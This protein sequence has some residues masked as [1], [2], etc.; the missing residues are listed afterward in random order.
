MLNELHKGMPAR[1]V[2]EEDYAT[3]CRT[4]LPQYKY[5]AKILYEM[6]PGIDPMLQHNQLVRLMVGK[7]STQLQGWY[8]MQDWVVVYPNALTAAE[9]TLL[10][11]ICEQGFGLPWH[12]LL[13]KWLNSYGWDMDRANRK[14]LAIVTLRNLQLEPDHLDALR[15]E[16]LDATLK[17]QALTEAEPQPGN[18]FAER[19]KLMAELRNAEAG[20]QAEADLRQTQVSAWASAYGTVKQ[21]RD[22]LLAI[23]AELAQQ[24]DTLRKRGKD[25]RKVYTLPTPTSHA[26]T[27]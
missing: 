17:L 22:H 13:T 5:R 14:G 11:L 4:G 8:R 9:V 23:N 15:E 26:A 3:L 27:V 21:E 1:P 19:T 12:K 10:D 18:P 25:P 24:L 16:V 6:V 7:A 20:K 2:A